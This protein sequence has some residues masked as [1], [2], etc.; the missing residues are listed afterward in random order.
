MYLFLIYRQAH[1]PTDARRAQGLL[2]QRAHVPVV[3]ELHRHP[4]CP[5]HRHA[6]LRRPAR[7]HLRLPVHRR[8]HADHAIRAVYLPLAGEIDSCEGPSRVR[9]PLRPHRPGYHLVAGR[10]RQLRAPDHVRWCGGWQEELKLSDLDPP[11]KKTARNAAM[12][13][14]TAG[15]YVERKEESYDCP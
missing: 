10:H 12:T 7:L 4:R 9:R 3:A 5:G 1:C 14:A 8:R 13:C 15:F 6:E 2:R 11:E